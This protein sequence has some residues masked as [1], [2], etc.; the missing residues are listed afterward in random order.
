[1]AETID[2]QTETEPSGGFA[3]L[4]PS[5]LGDLVSP[6][7]EASGATPAEAAAP[8]PSALESAAQAATGTTVEET[9]TPLDT[10]PPGA[11]GA[12]AAAVLPQLV[13]SEVKG[14]PGIFRRFRLPAGGRLRL[15]AAACTAAVLLA[16]AGAWIYFRHSPPSSHEPAQPGVGTIDPAPPDTAN[17]GSAETGPLSTAVRP[18]WGAVFREVDAFRRALFEQRDEIL[19]LQRHYD[20]GMRELEEEAVYLIKETGSGSLPAALKHKPLELALQGIQRR[21]GYRD[22]LDRPLRR[23]EAG[24]EELLFLERRARFD[25]QVADVA[26]GIDM[27]AHRQAIEAAFKAHEPTAELLSI[28]GTPP[29]A[30]IEAVWQRLAEQ[31]RQTT[32]TAEDRLNRDIA[33]EACAGSF[34]RLAELTGLSLKGASCLADS[35]ARELFLNRLSQL[36]PL[37]AQRLADWPGQWLCLNGLKRLPPE[38]A[39]MLFSWGGAWISLNGVGELSPEAARYIAG[40]R[41]RQLELMG[42]RKSVGVDA[43][44]K[45]EASGGKLFVPGEIRREIDLLQGIPVGPVRP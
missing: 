42:L 29:P 10:P 5:D 19:R 38:T 40:W 15:I 12:T 32:V 3:A 23:L 43:L 20:Y 21:Q 37:A 4:D 35:E 6:V 30:A 1:M 26:Q 41:G 24:Q 27:D 7:P 31:A 22:A 34:G 13:G 33:S 28:R 36:T 11:P 16:G 39:R 2:S 14:L 25:L 9:A 18:D 44:V 45:W 8:V 17:I